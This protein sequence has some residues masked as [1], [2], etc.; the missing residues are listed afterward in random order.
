MSSW[1]VAKSARSGVAT[2]A[3]AA[4]DTVL[5]SRPMQHLPGLGALALSASRSADELRARAEEVLASGDYQRTLPQTPARF[6][7]P[8]GG[9]E[10][11]LRIL[12]WTAL[13]VLVVIAISWVVR[14]L[15]GGARDA[16]VIEPG[17]EGP[18]AIPIAGAEA[19]AAER[20]WAEAI[21]ALLLE[22]LEALSRAARLAPSLTSREIAEQVALPSRAREALRGLVLAV[23][24]S[25]FGGAPAG[26]EDYRAC[27]GRFHAFLDTYRSAA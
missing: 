15:A 26:E 9:F 4:K 27:L 1:G 11:L 18:A 23:E 7:L 17:G 21:H 10:L 2:G 12:L 6:E 25:R 16:E 5:P 13:A 3:A 8:L 24:V 22:T 14:R 19:L 20:R